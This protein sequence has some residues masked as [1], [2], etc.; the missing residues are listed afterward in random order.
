MIQPSKAERM[1]VLLLRL[2]GAVTMLAILAVFMPRSW[3]AACHERL[4]LGKFPE[5]PIVEYLARTVSAL[6]FVLGGLMWVAAGDVRRYRV[7][8]RYVGLV[9]LVGGIM[10]LA[11]NFAICM[12]AYWT[13]SE[14]PP[15]V[16]LGLALLLLQ[17]RV[18]RNC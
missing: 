16:L 7:P 17:R 4:G 8:V 11:L 15:T 1:L 6:Y 9:M 12:P 2:A 3:M 10:V 18:E 5:G 13:A 14:G